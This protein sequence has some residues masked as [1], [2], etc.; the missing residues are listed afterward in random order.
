M[1]LTRIM[2]HK[3]APTLY[4]ILYVRTLL[5][6]IYDI[7]ECLFA[8]MTLYKDIHIYTIYSQYM[9]IYISIFIHNIYIY[10]YTFI[11]VELRESNIYTHTYINI[12]TV[13][14]T[15]EEREWGEL[16]IKHEIF[17]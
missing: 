1:K 9:H 14:Y 11:F 5:I 17:S 2:P 12:Y 8:T 6:T 4:T 16:N 10:I 13:V 3:Q 15:Q 7:F